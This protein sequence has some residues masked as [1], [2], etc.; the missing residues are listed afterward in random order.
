MT[1]YSTEDKDKTPFVN[2]EDPKLLLVKGNLSKE[3]A[4]LYVKKVANAITKV[5]EKH[6]VAVLRCVG[7]ASVNNAVKA[8]II[9]SGGVK[10]QGVKLHLTPS[11]HNVKFDG[12]GEKTSVVME[13]RRS[14][15]NAE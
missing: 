2:S 9:A 1:D 14:D 15:N 5:I 3:D 4:K 11:F 8:T 6:T 12:V 10:E 7:A 13:V